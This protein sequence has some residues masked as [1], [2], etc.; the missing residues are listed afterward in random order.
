MK[1][2][3]NTR[4]L[5][6]IL[7]ESPRISPEWWDQQRKA[8]LSLMAER[9]N[10]PEHLIVVTAQHPLEEGVKPNA[11]FRAR[12]DAAIL[13]ISELASSG[14]VMHVYVPGSVHM[15]K[16][17]V[18]KVSLASA[19]T[20]YLKSHIDQNVAVNVIIHGDNLNTLYKG[21]EGVYN[22]GDEAFVTASF[23]KDNDS[24]GS[25]TV[26]CSPGQAHRWELQSIANGVL[27]E[28]IRITPKD[29]HMYHE[30]RGDAMLDKTVVY[31]LN[32]DPTW[33]GSDSFLGQL[34]REQ[35][36]PKTS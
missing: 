26:F 22:G 33:Q 36:R 12:L 5:D 20:T 27:P 32:F 16:G 31:T 14:A 1:K 34:T 6:S 19:G 3:N 28:F 7:E 2:R 24:L 25:M 17:V 9:T 13:Q 30:D 23:F 21:N 11:E 18:D 4:T 15:D 10:Q 8:A 35:R 29:M